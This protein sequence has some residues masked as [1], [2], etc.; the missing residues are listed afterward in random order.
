[1]HQLDVVGAYL[2]AHMAGELYCWAPD[3]VAK[4]EDEAWQILS[5]VYGEKQAGAAWKEMFVQLLKEF[6]FK[7]AN[8]DETMFV[9]RDGVTDRVIIA[10]IYVDDAIVAESWPSKYNALLQHLSKKIE[11]TDEGSLHWYL[12]VSYKYN[13][14]GSKILLNQKAYVEKVA[15]THDLDPDAT[16]GP[17][18]PMDSRFT[19]HPDDVPNDEDVDVE[20]RTKTKRLIGSLL[21]PAGWARP[22]CTYAI[23][24]LARHAAK[25]W[26]EI[27][28]AALRILKFMIKTK[29]T[30][31]E[32]SRHAEDRH[33]HMLNE[34]YC[35]VDASFADDPIKR[36]STVGHLVFMNGGPIVFKSKLAPTMVGS[37]THA[38]LAG[39]CLAAQ[40]VVQLR[41]ILETLGFPQDGPTAMYEDN[42]S[43]MAIANNKRTG[44]NK[45]IDVRYNIVR[46]Y[47]RTMQIVFVP[48]NTKKQH[49]DGMTK[50]LG[51]TPFKDCNSH[52]VVD[53]AEYV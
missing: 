6:G 4:Y 42:E 52:V 25:P 39:A 31:I 16:T 40:D 38:E 49:A 18:T 9:L 14:D 32:F 1:M 21:F 12:S 29:D 23:H 2:Y 43:C 28:E 34:L 41:G 37:S 30:G 22:D 47:V 24:R 51:P 26:P 46:E 45:F 35:F 53:G 17:K 10:C 15:V 33:G 8:I 27:Y 44:G 13:I 50:P 5:S 36:R 19:V 3:G 48:I 20:L 11:V 7:P